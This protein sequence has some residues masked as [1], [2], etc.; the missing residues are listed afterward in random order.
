MPLDTGLNGSTSVVLDGS[1]DGKVGYNLYLTL[2][3]NFG[4]EESRGSVEGVL[5]ARRHLLLT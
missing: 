5:G 1:V 3:W 2:V 4:S